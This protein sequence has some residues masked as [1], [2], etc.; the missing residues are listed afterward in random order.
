MGHGLNLI[1]APEELPAPPK[2]MPSCPKTCAYQMAKFTLPLTKAEF[3]NSQLL[4][5]LQAIGNRRLAAR[6]AH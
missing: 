5:P 1:V 6:K 3:G 2:S 4:A